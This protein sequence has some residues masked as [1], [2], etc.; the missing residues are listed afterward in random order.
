MDD[1][2]PELH[3]TPDVG[4]MQP[5]QIISQHDIAMLQKRLDLVM[6]QSAATAS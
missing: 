2:P 3:P 6:Q 4:E 5:Q 1:E